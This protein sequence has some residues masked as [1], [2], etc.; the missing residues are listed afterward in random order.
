[1]ESWKPP[2]YSISI[3]T[4]TI[5]CIKNMKTFTITIIIQEY[6]TTYS[7]TIANTTVN[8]ERVVHYALD[9]AYSDKKN[10]TKIDW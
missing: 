7:S 1:M 5:Y 9:H 8:V 3:S 6:I 4:S 2:V 10:N